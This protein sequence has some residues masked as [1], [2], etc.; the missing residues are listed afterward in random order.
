VNKILDKCLELVDP[1]TGLIKKL[2]VTLEPPG[3][4]KLFRAVAIAGD[5]TRYNNS[6][7]WFELTSG[8]GLT[9]EDAIMSAIGEFIERYCACMYDER[10]I[11]RAT[12]NQ[13]I[14]KGYNAVDPSS[15]A[16]FSETQYNRKSFPFKRFTKETP[17]S[18][19]EGKSLITNERLWV[20]ACFVWMVPFPERIIF[21]NSNGLAASPSIKDAI[22]HALCEVIERDALMITWFNKLPLPR[23]LVEEVS[24]DLYQL[25]NSRCI[26]CGLEYHF[27]DITLDVKIPSVMAI[28]IDRNDNTG[29]LVGASSSVNIE[30]AILKSFFEGCFQAR[31]TVKKL[32]KGKILT[33]KEGLK[34]LLLYHALPYANVQAIQHFD[35][36]LKSPAVKPDYP[37]VTRENSLNY[38]LN[39]VKEAGMDVIM[40][41]ITTPDIAD[42]GF[43]VVRVIIP[44]TISVNAGKDKR[45]LG[46]E[47]LYTVPQLLGYKDKRG[48]ENELNP[49]PHPFL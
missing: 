23:I 38:A 22:L 33:K 35:F 9:R 44:G 6:E 49:L 34:H 21:P 19:V 10:R 37:H 1:K 30:E 15:F 31:P 13:M 42:I 8:I 25:I 47:R 20:P 27:I 43:H 24:K 28:S 14:K 4:V 7:W 2:L 48:H 40:V 45:F 26:N 11:I 18:W 41:E 46:G 16:L 5:L 29:V 36:L 12:Y 17:V 39:K 32:S 3:E